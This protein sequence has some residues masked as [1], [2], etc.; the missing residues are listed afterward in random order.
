MAA[1]TPIPGHVYRRRGLLST[2]LAL[3]P[4]HRRFDP[5]AEAIAQGGAVVDAPNVSV[6]HDAEDVEKRGLPSGSG[7][8]PGS[9]SSYDKGKPYGRRE[10]GEGE[11]V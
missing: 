4:P 11:M 3:P 7:G 5:E 9:G 8:R 10:D 2:T 6:R 1:P